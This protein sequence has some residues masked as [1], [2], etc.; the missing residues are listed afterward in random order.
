M[1]SIT[2]IELLGFPKITHKEEQVI[3]SFL[4]GCEMIELTPAIREQAIQL[5]RSTKIKTPDAII[6]AS[7]LVLD[8]PL[9][10]EDKDFNQVPGLEVV[11]L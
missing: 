2:A 6:A 4:A 3:R 5:K 7:A 10:T 9:A 11:R 1:S 8:L